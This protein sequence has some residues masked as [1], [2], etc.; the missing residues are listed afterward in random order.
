MFSQFSRAAVVAAPVVKTIVPALHTSH[1]VAAPVLAHGHHGYGH[2]G[3]LGLHGA[4][5]YGHGLGHGLY[6][7]LGHL[8]YGHGLGH[9]GY[10]HGG[11]LIKK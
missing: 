6:G 9:L 8:G 5:L 11:L 4:P 10:G 3:L 7:G 1:V 2:G